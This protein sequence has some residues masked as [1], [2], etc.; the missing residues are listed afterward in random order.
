M[1]V[2]QRVD[3]RIKRLRNV[4]EKLGSVV[5]AYSGGVDST[6]LLKVCLD[7][8]GRENV[9]AV[10]AVS[11][12]YPV[13][14]V[15]T[16]RTLAEELGAKHLLI[17]TEE[18]NDE[19]F[20]KNTPQRCYYCKLEL[21]TKLLAI[22][23]AHGLRFVV[24]GSNADDASDYRPGM[25]AGCELGVISP[26]KEA[27]LRKADIR[28]LSRMLGLPTWNKPTMAC[29]ASRFPYYYEITDEELR[30]VAEGERF[31]RGIGLTQ[32]R[33]RHHGY[34]ARIEI[35]PNEFSLLM[36]DGVREMVVERLRSIGYIWVTLDLR[37]YQSGSF[38]EMLLKGK[39]ET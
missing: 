38:N 5:V 12:L 2:M 26:L 37:G 30:M 22:A 14:E 3:E 13:E 4:I 24:D 8:L 17:E 10:T 9:L 34:L 6:L 28:E 36:A 19:R 11:P 27:N 18:M 29:L 15:E 23:K 7:T 39:A 32:V 25:Q 35:L 1:E 20:I 33:L 21:F 16:A 31:L